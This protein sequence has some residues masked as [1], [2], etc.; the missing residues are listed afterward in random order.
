MPFSFVAVL[1]FFCSVSSAQTS[2]TEKYTNNPSLV[3]YPNPATNSLKIRIPETWQGR[4]IH[5]EMYDQSGNIIMMKVFTN[6][7]DVI[8]MALDLPGG[9]YIV[10][11]KQK[12]KKMLTEN[13]LVQY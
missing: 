6:T 11:L 5:L 2:V 4:D 1:F 3:V 7:A 9:T 12:G 10:K 8:T 13:L